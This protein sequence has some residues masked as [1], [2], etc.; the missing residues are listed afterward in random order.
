MRVILPV[1]TSVLLASLTL[2]GCSKPENR[3]PQPN[4]SGEATAGASRAVLAGDQLT[5]VMEMHD[6][7]ITLLSARDAAVYGEVDVAR[8]Q[9]TELATQPM[10]EGVSSIWAPEVLELH[11]RAGRGARAELPEGVTQGIAHTAQ[12]CGSCHTATGQSPELAGQMDPPSPDTPSELMRRHA[13]A[14][15][16]LWDGLIIPSE[17]RW[18]QG[19]IVLATSKLEPNT[20]FQDEYLAEVGAERVHGLQEAT[21][22]IVAAKGW[23]ERAEAYGELLNSCSSCHSR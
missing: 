12:S 5:R 15:Q 8:E 18:A 10:P 7:Y 16:Q 19:G 21:K 3:E 9:L 17:E 20:L 13:W 14:A 23:E 2:S 11:V 6:S 4:T 22:S 1:L